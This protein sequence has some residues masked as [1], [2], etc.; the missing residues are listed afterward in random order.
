MILAFTCLTIATIGLLAL[1]KYRFDRIW[2][3]LSFPVVAFCV[4]YFVSSN[5]L[6]R[7]SGYIAA[8]Y[9][10]IIARWIMVWRAKDMDKHIS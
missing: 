2:W 5:E 6:V 9:M 4:M 10:V 3:S 7:A 8:I 1:S